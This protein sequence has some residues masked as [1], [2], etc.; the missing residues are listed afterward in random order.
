MGESLKGIIYYLSYM[1]PLKR[2]RIGADLALKVVLTH[3]L[4]PR[5]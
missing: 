2:L 1:T 3:I 4:F 5:G